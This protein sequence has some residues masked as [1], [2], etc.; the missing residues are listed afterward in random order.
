MIGSA[1]A[2]KTVESYDY[3]R[4][5]FYA[6]MI[7]RGFPQFWKLWEVSSLQDTKHPDFRMRLARELEGAAKYMASL[8]GP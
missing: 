6:S 1:E 8:T 3:G 2:N 4:G 5:A 7:S